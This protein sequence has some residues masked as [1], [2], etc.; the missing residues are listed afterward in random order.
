MGRDEW[1]P[2]QD[3]SLHVSLQSGPHTYKHCDVLLKTLLACRNS[4]KL[5]LTSTSPMLAALQLCMT[6]CCFM[7]GS[8]VINGAFDSA[9]A[10]SMVSAVADTRHV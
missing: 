6:F 8:S 3:T 9:A 10:S 4:C 5:A 1:S 2:Q 7:L